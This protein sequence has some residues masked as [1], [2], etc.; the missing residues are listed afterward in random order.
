MA[1]NKSTGKR[2]ITGT[3]ITTKSW[4]GSHEEMV[5]EDLGDGKVICE[6]SRGRYITDK[7]RLDNGLA[8]QNRASLKRI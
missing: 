8:D 2:H 4:F 5:V 7:D 6:D 1:R 3:T